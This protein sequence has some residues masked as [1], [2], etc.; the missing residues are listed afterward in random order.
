MEV[1]TYMYMYNTVYFTL[2]K[3]SMFHNAPSWAL[4]NNLALYFSLPFMPVHGVLHFTETWTLL[5]RQ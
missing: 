4:F 5:Q 1:L 2:N 3:K